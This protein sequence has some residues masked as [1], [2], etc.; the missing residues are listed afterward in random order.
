MAHPCLPYPIEHPQ[1]QADPMGTT[2]QRTTATDKESRK[3]KKNRMTQHECRN[4]K[5]T[6]DLQ[7]WEVLEALLN[8]AGECPSGR[9]LLSSIFRTPGFMAAMDVARKCHPRSDGRGICIQTLLKLSNEESNGMWEA[10]AE[11]E[12]E[13]A[14]EEEEEPACAMEEEEE[15]PA[16]AMEEEEEEVVD[17]AEMPSGREKQEY[18]DTIAQIILSLKATQGGDEAAP[19]KALPLEAL[20]ILPIM[21][22]PSGIVTGDYPLLPPE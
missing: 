21:A 8:H 5:K 9:S 18:E 17:V 14:M 2:L 19:A 16:C 3:R 13:C 7:L 6:I 4:R 11:N 22:I 12:G 10:D 15:E 1:R 20:P